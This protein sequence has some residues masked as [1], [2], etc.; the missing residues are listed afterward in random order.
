MNPKK[1]VDLTSSMQFPPLSDTEEK[2]LKADLYKLVDQYLPGKSASE[3]N[4]FVNYLIKA[5]KFFVLFVSTLS[6]VLK[7]KLN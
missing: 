3:K 6:L 1:F 5:V 7:Y 2:Q 4:S